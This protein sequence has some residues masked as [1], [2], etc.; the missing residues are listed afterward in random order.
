MENG[1]FNEIVLVIDKELGLKQKIPHS[2]I[3]CRHKTSYISVQKKILQNLKSKTHIQPDDL[4]LL[5]ARELKPKQANQRRFHFFTYTGRFLGF[6]WRV[7][8]TRR[9]W[10]REHVFCYL[11]RLKTSSAESKANFNP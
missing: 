6:C 3:E 1:W 2:Q 8:A 9:A 11:T 4:P 7:I 10:L 5:G